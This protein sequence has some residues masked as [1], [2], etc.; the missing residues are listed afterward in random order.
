MNRTARIGILAASVAIFCY[1][2]SATFLGARRTTSVQIADSLRRGFAKDSVRLRRRA[3]H[4]LSDCRV[5]A[6]LAQ[7][8]YEIQTGLPC[9]RS[10]FLLIFAYRAAVR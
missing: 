8:P 3:E 7:A 4:A 2:G 9:R 1:V 6:R 10:A 5:A